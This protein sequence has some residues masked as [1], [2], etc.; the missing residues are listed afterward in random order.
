VE[1]RRIGRRYVLQ[2]PDRGGPGASV[3]RALD[4]ATQAPVL[5]TLLEPGPAAAAA[6]DALAG[7]RHPALPVVLDH[8]TD[9]DGTCYLATPMRSGRSARAGLAG[10][11]LPGPDLARLGA[12]LAGALAVLHAHGLVQGALSL[13]AVILDEQ[14]RPRLQDLATAG[15]ARPPARPD[16]DLRALGAL[17]REAAGADP[18]GDLLGRPGLPPRLAALMGALT[19]GAPPPAAAAAEAL[20]RIAD[21]VDPEPAAAV[22]PAPA[23]AEA[24]PAPRRRGLRIL[25]GIL[26][27]AVLVLAA[28]AVARV[29]DDRDAQRRAVDE[30]APAPITTVSPDPADEEPLVLPTAEAATTVAEEPVATTAEASEPASAPSGPVPIGIAAVEAVDPAGDRAE[31]GDLARRAIDRSPRSAWSTEEYKDAGFGGK[32]GVGLVLRLEAPARVTA[33]VVR[34]RP[35]GAVVEVYALRGDVPETAPRGWERAAGP[36][37]LARP[38]TRIP[39]ERRRAATALLVWITRLP[40]PNGANAVEIADVRVLGRPRGA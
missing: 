37:E 5:V 10:A 38:R 8:G 24:P 36:V 28:I 39:V 15:L 34:A 30:A 33:L 32:D 23:A 22:G 4:E 6:L 3:W 17:L 13:D 9:P 20:R 31:N 11:P 26:G 27:V 19:G 29:V 1:G 2:V 16:D 25:V 12:D 14:G 35:A 40:G 18:V 21:G 7:V